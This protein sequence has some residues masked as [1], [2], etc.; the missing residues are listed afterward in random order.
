MAK[1]R[2]EGPFNIPMQRKQGGRIIQEDLSDFWN[3]NKKLCKSKGCYVFAI[4]AGGG[5]TPLYVGKATKGFIKECF[6]DHKLKHYQY[7]LSDYERGTP[8]MFFVVLP[9]LKGSPNL[10][11]IDE[12]ENFLI[13]VGRSVNPE[14]RNI[15]G[16]IKPDWGIKG[17]IR[18]GKGKSPK[19]AHEFKKLLKLQ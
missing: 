7:A 4:R 19:S 2:I 9:T 10:K 16:N 18:G 6:A 14:L 5:Y 17:V 1:F 8:V 15:K 12:V 13:Q 11:E 3:K